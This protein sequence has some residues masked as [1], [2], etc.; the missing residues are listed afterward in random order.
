MWA[1]VVV[2]S[3][4]WAQDLPEMPL[5]ES[6]H[7]I[8]ALAAD[9]A[10]QPLAERVRLRRPHRRFQDSRPPGTSRDRQTVSRAST[11]EY[12]ARDAE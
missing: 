8:Q 1:A 7:E 4:R 2:G 10:D 3:D 9:R 12:T 11:R 6:N 5:I